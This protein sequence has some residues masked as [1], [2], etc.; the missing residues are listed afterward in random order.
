ML[1]E[2]IGE[3]RPRPDL[4]LRSSIERVRDFCLSLYHLAPIGY[5]T[6]AADGRIL[7]ANYTAGCML[8]VPSHRL[9]GAL[10]PSFVVRDAEGPLWLHLDHV[11]ATGARATVELRMQRPTGTRFHASLETVPFDSVA[12]DCDEPSFL[13]AMVDITE[14]KLLE[15]TLL[16]REATLRTIFATD[17][18][19]LIGVDEHGAIRSFGAGAERMFGFRSREAIGRHVGVLFDVAAPPLGS[20]AGSTPTGA[21]VQRARCRRRDGE[22]FDAEVS[23]GRLAGASY[24]ILVVRDVSTQ[25]ETEHALEQ[26]RL[27]ET[28]G[29][30]ATS[31]V[32]DTNNL[33]MRIV[34][35]AESLAGAAGDPET[36]RRRAEE[37]RRMA[38]GGAAVVRRL[39]GVMSGGSER[40]GGLDIDAAL[41]SMSALVEALLGEGVE[42]SIAL[43]AEGA[44]VACDQGQL[45]QLVL[46]LIGNARD[47]LPHGGRVEIVTSRV[48]LEG[49]A[50]VR[51]VVCDD[52]VG[53]SDDVRARAMTRGYTTKENG[54]GLGLD[55]VRRIVEGA[56]GRIAIA[57]RPRAGT[58]F[59]IDLPALELEAEA[60]VPR[61][62]VSTLLLVERDTLV[63]STLRAWLERGGHRVLE[64]ADAPEA[65]EQCHAHRGGIDAMLTDVLSGGAE[66]AERIRE[67]CP[68]I[69]VLFMSGHPRAD[70]VRGGMLAPDVFLLG[71][72]C[73]ER[74]LA[75]ALRQV[76]GEAEPSAILVVEDDPLSRRMV[77]TLLEQRGYDVQ[78]AATIREAIM[79][80]RSAPRPVDVVLSDARLPDGSVSDLLRMLRKSEPAPPVLVL[81]GLDESIDPEIASVLRMPRTSFM[82]KPAGIDDLV[83]EIEELRARS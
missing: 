17:P 51:L 75:E 32:H 72:P 50:H 22:L 23:V 67:Q 4:Q 16:E 42:L 76:V 59:T 15:A 63:R 54:S 1:A 83:R 29:R 37:L 48:E 7:E 44:R 41:E 33:L 79:Q 3:K 55:T 24:A 45:A 61:A 81:S 18:D 19:G 73:S 21:I 71:K 53:M 47:A 27:L 62:K 38:L 70:L 64:A 49:R 52:G 56:Q 35:A 65:L 58:A 34:S 26:A 60:P 5:L 8:G 39:S 78:L 31:I 12:L 28:A 30:L 25:R 66:L 69:S 2:G 43:G 14:R 82:Q 13:T 36:V 68:T 10:L 80:Y 77:G 6:H 11:A 40:D 74:E 20:R 57:S 46:N 9:H